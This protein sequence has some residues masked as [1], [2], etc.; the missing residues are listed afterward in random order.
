MTSEP[1]NS[2]FIFIPKVSKVGTLVSTALTEMGK[3]NE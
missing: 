2:D 1:A 3:N